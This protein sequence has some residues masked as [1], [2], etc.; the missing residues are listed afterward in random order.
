MV[1]GGKPCCRRR[2]ET[3]VEG[4]AAD[5][6]VRNATER[7]RSLRLKSIGLSSKSIGLRGKSIGVLVGSL[8]TTRVEAFD[9]ER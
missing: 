6:Y 5:R 9:C 8:C 1:E 2:P 7:A 4:G 3:T